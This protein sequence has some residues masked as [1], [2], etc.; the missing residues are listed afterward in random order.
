[1][2]VRAGSTLKFAKNSRGKTVMVHAGSNGLQILLKFG[3]DWWLGKRKR[4][5][6]YRTG[7][8]YSDMEVALN[9]HL[10]EVD[11]ASLHDCS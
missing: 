4:L 11:I 8:L 5:V 3:I 2:V 1:M 7:R 6:R 9:S 10:V